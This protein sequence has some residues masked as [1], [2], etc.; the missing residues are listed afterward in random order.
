MI[1]FIAGIL[2]NELLLMI[3]GIADLS[4]HA[5]PYTNEALLFA[6]LVL[7]AGIFGLNFKNKRTY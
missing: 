1:V 4:Y 6:A 3:E 5:V 7:M 2:L